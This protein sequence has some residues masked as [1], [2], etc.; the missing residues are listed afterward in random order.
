[1]LREQWQRNLLGVLI[2]TFV[3]ILG[4]NLVFPFMPL[5]I[6]TLGVSDAREAAF[7]T[8]LVGLLTG[9]V[10]FIAQP[11]WGQLADRR[12]RRPMLL[13][14]VVGGG[15]GLVALAAVTNI[16]QLI[17]ARMY[18][19]A[20]S[21]TA[22]AANPLVTAGTPPRYL[23]TAMGS[24]QSTVYLSTMLGPPIGGVLA[25]WF[26]FRGAFLVVAALY[27]LAALPAYLLIRETFTRP[28]QTR[29]LLRAVTGDFRG[30]LRNRAI[31]L[32][33]AA[34]LLALIGS[35]L[36]F[37]ITPLIVGD[38]VGE[39]SVKRM[40]GVAFGAQ[41]LA[42]ALA[43]VV[44]G[45]LVTRFGQ[46]RL[47]AVTAPAAALTYLLLWVAPT[48]WSLVALLAVLGLIQGIQ[49]P[50]INALI[51]ARSPR[52][53]VGSIFGVLSSVNNIAYSGA[54]FLG[55]VLARE[56]G[57]RSIFPVAAL[58]LIGM[59]LM[60]GVATRPMGEPARRAL[61]AGE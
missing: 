30:V 15:T 55:G 54:P 7:Y 21:G 57:L 61:P 40:T 18:F 35:N 53:G 13:R 8:G 29:S 37:P 5:F 4:Y 45:R 26:G 3:S 10:S 19:A 43:A 42:S 44:L 47:L 2:A 58:F 16:G 24:L 9:V 11:I 38:L 32:P 25:S 23:S 50:A 20:L 14:A 27:I 17:V 36:V 41:G 6:Q 31:A 51:A 28:A 22:P 52:D 49:I 33:M 39:A 34:A 59:T 46:R 60:V 12:G 56:F 48:Y 1:M